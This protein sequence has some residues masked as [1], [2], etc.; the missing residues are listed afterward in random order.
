[1]N[2]RLLPTEVATDDK[3]GRCPGSKCC[4][5]ITQSIPTPRTKADFDH[6]LWQ[7]SHRGITIYKDEDGWYLLVEATCS[8]LEAD[9]RCG[10][11]E[12]RPQVCRDYSN[13][14]CELD[15]PAEKHFELLFTDYA[16]LHGYVSRRFSRPAR[17]LRKSPQRRNRRSP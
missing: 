11:Y 16:S 9:G 8:H 13:D 12:S 14:Y 3:C 6:L 7:V 15:E 17:A 4:T 1:M 10:I 5:Y 2:A